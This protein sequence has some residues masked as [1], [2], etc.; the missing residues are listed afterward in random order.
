MFWIVLVY[1]YNYPYCDVFSVFFGTLTSMHIYMETYNCWSWDLLWANQSVSTAFGRH[2][3]TLNSFQP[4]HLL[5]AGASHGHSYNTCK[6]EKHVDEALW[7]YLWLYYL[8][9]FSDQDRVV[10]FFPVGPWGNGKVSPKDVEDAVELLRKGME[11]TG[12]CL[13]MPMVA[14]AS[15]DAC[16]SLQHKTA[17]TDYIYI[18]YLLCCF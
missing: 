15:L 5:V 6:Y 2:H 16:P 3:G 7:L 4:W 13:D 8:Y 17:Y 9:S 18:L 1:L 10:L 11:L 12:W 14:R